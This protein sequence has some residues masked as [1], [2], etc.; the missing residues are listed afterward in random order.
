[1]LW[2]TKVTLPFSERADELGSNKKERLF[3]TGK[4]SPRG[5]KRAGLTRPSE[6]TLK[7]R[8]HWVGQQKHFPSPPR[9]VYFSHTGESGKL[10]PV[11]VKDSKNYDM[12]S[13]RGKS[14]PR[15]EKGSLG[16]FLGHPVRS[17]ASLSTTEEPSPIHS[18]SGNS[19]AQLPNSLK[20]W[21]ENLLF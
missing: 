1:M 10:K 12:V 15:G 5:K 18:E 2:A 6:T 9:N 16:V 20:K 7:E 3:F 4:G 13:I 11:F 19:T 17:L 21:R 14:K 8:A